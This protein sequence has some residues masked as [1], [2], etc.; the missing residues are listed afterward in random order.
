MLADAAGQRSVTVRPNADGSVTLGGDVAPMTARAQARD[1][2]L[3]VEVQRD[4]T[5]DVVASFA[6]A[7]VRHGDVLHVFG[8]G[9]RALLTRIDPLAHADDEPAHA[10]HLTAPMSGTV[11]AVL[12]KPGDTVDQG[13]PLIV[14]EAMKMEHTI[15]APA[16]GTVAAVN[17]AVG[18]RVAEGA[19]LVDVDDA[20]DAKA[21]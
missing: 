4:G 13:A 3:F 6:A 16:A 1:G 5:P 9:A 14:L 12:V 19:D 11:V 21:Q 20:T 18:D 10:G 17:Y 2:R 7:V 8:S 15:T